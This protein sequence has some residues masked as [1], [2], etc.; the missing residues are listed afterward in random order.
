MVPTIET[1]NK[2]VCL[3]LWE[4]GLTKGVIT[5][6]VGCDFVLEVQQLHGLRAYLLLST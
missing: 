6:S 2:G 5:P 4:G 3:C 1:Q